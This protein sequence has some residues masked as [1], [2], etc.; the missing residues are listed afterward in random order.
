LQ[1]DESEDSHNH[2]GSIKSVSESKG[3]SANQVLRDS[4][5]LLEDLWSFP[6]E[7]ATKEV[8]HMP[9]IAPLH[10]NHIILIGSGGGMED[11]DSP[12]IGNLKTIRQRN[13]RKPTPQ[14]TKRGVTLQMISELYNS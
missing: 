12:L 1:V 2:L 9:L 4:E 13:G 6:E 8:I 7:L 10:S 14:R 3:S 11:C 5:N